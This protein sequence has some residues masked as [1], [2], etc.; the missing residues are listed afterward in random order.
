MWGAAPGESPSALEPA[1]LGRRH[2]Q[3]GNRAGATTQHTP[4]QR[5]FVSMEMDSRA[6]QEMRVTLL[7][8][9]INDIALLGTEITGPARLDR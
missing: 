6:S 2:L 3:P 7:Y 8:L 4:R 5:A 9:V 1:G